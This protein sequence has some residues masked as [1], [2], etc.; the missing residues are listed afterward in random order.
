M[1]SSISARDMVDC[2]T[3]L[4]R[5]EF[6]S[7]LNSSTT[8]R[9]IVKRLP[10]SDQAKWK[11][12][13]L[14]IIQSGRLATFH[15]LTDFVKYR[16]RAASTTYGRDFAESSKQ[17]PQPKETSNKKPKAKPAAKPNVTTIST[18]IQKPAEPKKDGKS[19]VQL[20]RLLH[21]LRSPRRRRVCSVTLLATALKDASSTRS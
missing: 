14:T 18:T 3:V 21:R 20:H 13:A 2:Y 1:V 4:S 16:A 6:S 7:D 8:I 5:M 10:R 19:K 9:D 12:K 17:K 11:D 15:D